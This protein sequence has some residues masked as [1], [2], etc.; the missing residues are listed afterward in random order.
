MVK[1]KK[2]TQIFSLKENL[3]MVLPVKYTPYSD[4]NYYLE[5]LPYI[6][7]YRNWELGMAP[8]FEDL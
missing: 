2:K 5:K 6:K 7:D 3:K 1:I 4:V 8:Q